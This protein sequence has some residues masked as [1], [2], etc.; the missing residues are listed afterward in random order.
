[1]TETELQQ[2]LNTSVE[3]VDA[4]SDLVH[5]ARQG[6][7]RRLR[8]RRFTAIAAMTVSVAA[9][10]GV[11][12][13]GQDLLRDRQDQSTVAAVPGPGDPYGFLMNRPTQGDL[14]GDQTYVAQVLA[15]WEKSHAN[16]P[17]QSRGIFDDLRGKPKVAWA[18]NTPGGR[19]AIV[20]Q[21]SY[22][23][24][25]EDIQL[26]H[27]GIYTVIGFVGEG[28]DRRATLVGDAYPAPRSNL[29]LG[30]LT[31]SNSKALVVLDTGQRMGWSRAR[32]YAADGSSRHEYAPLTFSDGVSIT[33]I[34]A[35]TD[36]GGV[37]I[38]PLPA[39]TYSGLYVAGVPW[40]GETMPD[41]RLW[42]TAGSWP[43]GAGAEAL[44]E[45]APDF[46]VSAV[47]S[48]VDPDRNGAYVSLWHAYGKTPDGSDLVVGEFALDTDSTRVYAVLKN[49]AGK[50][51]VATGGIPD[52]KAPLPVSIRLPNGQGWAVA[53]KGAQLSYRFDG[54]SWSQPRANAVLVPDGTN[55]EVKVTIGGAA[56]T[57]QLH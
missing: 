30:F 42:P 4:P 48:V 57:V 9:V 12:I 35:G 43:L 23:H 8:R 13:V 14:A 15:A 3:A 34:P 16:S 41:P 47:D 46:F 49:R 54:G 1:M 21:H 31:G 27:E 51:T 24:E 5:R 37:R 11:A 50:T 45:S 6:G 53:N 36:L 17:N 18:G 29:T 22:L 55:T 26:D 33:A 44:R 32:T 52:K 20:V 19:A 38:S 39:A 40:P 7:A 28:A 56:K 2:R 25:H 10:G